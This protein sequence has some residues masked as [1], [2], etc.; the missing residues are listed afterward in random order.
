[1]LSENRKLIT[2]FFLILT[3]TAVIPMNLYIPTNSSGELKGDQEIQQLDHRSSYVV[4][5]ITVNKVQGTSLTKEQVEANIKKMNE[6]YNCEVAIFVWDGKIHE[7]P[8]P[9]GNGDGKIDDN[10]EH[11]DKVRDKAEENANSEGVSITVAEDLGDANTNG[12]TY[13]GGAHS[14]IVRAGTDG[15][16]WAHEIQHALG[17]SH[18]RSKPADEDIN[19]DEPGNGS[20]WDVNGDGKVT[21]ADKEYNLW[22]RKSDR[23]GDKMN[24]DVIYG[25]ASALPGVKSKTRPARSTLAPVPPKKAGTKNDTRGDPANYTSGE[26]KP[27]ALYID[28]IRGGIRINFT[29]LWLEF[30]IQIASSPIVN[31]TY[32]F[33]IDDK[34]LEGDPATG[35]ADT[36]V[37]FSTMVFGTYEWGE[38]W[39]L[40]WTGAS[41]DWGTGPIAY[42]GQKSFNE[43]I[44]YD[45]DTGSGW[46]DSFF[47]V[48]LSAE[49]PEPGLVASLANNPFNMWL[50]S[51]QLDSS[52][53]PLLFDNT[54]KK[55]ILLSDNPEATIAVNNDS[56][57]A[58]ETMTIN[59]TAFT[60]N[61]NV[62]VY[63]DGINLTTVNTDSNGNFVV[64]VTIPSEMNKTN[65]ILIVRDPQ[66]K[67]DAMYIDVQKLSVEVSAPIAGFEYIMAIIGLISVIIIFFKNKYPLA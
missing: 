10:R 51:Y 12:M 2:A 46:V 48:V 61:S 65:A 59:G 52:P 50:R 56:V 40:T 39:L 63:L 8:D 20:G 14:A 30:W 4:I 35:G 1:M 67:R 16:T 27:T 43:T 18:G 13:V 36:I 66:G 17:Q 23:T 3:L 19:G 25:N 29:N 34:P 64:N 15:D 45:N 58:G 60:P 54:S 9:E 49:F 24:H 37:E 26:S 7:I 62:T 33:I 44:N 6:I 22:G 57:K 55:E 31:C 28:I 5:P 47:D 53:E 41:W 11:R 42:F 38:V 32:D 21:N